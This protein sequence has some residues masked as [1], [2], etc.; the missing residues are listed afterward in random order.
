M[1]KI[2]VS[3]V[4][5]L[6][7]TAGFAHEKQ[8]LVRFDMKHVVH[9]INS[10]QVER[11]QIANRRVAT[12]GIVV[13]I[14]GYFLW[15]SFFGQNAPP[16]SES[17]KSLSSAGR[18][19][20]GDGQKELNLSL[21]KKLDDDRSFSGRFKQACYSAGILFI[22][23]RVLG[24]MGNVSGSWLDYFAYKDP[25]IDQLSRDAS[26]RWR[27]LS[28][29][30][31]A[32]QKN[33]K[34]FEGMLEKNRDLGAFVTADIFVAYGGLIHTLEMAVAHI[35][36]KIAQNKSCGIS[37]QATMQSFKNISETFNR[38]AEILEVLVS[39]GTTKIDRTK[40]ELFTQVFNAA[41]VDFVNAV[42]SVQGELGE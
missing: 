42:D 2:I 7:F 1:N 3:I 23:E 22:L 16:P 24:V 11:H 34:E 41:C 21:A 5:S 28:D 13:P 31:M 9:K 25:S 14:A 12:A 40:L 8:R 6:F 4:C 30:L 15:Q 29:V 17:K 37:I 18:I 38:A 26:L 32:Y 35:L 33:Q 27:V 36:A 19:E 39:D 20:Q 10:I